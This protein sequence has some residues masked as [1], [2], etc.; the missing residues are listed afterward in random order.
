M[1]A[2]SEYID[3]HKKILKYILKRDEQPLEEKYEKMFNGL[4]ETLVRRKRTLLSIFLFHLA[5]MTQR[6][7]NIIIATFLLYSSV[8]VQK[9]YRFHDFMTTQRNQSESESIQ[10]DAVIMSCL[11]LFLEV[12]GH[13]FISLPSAFGYFI[14]T[15]QNQY[16]MIVFILSMCA[17]FGRHEIGMRFGQM[18]FAKH[19]VPEMRLEGA[20][21]SILTPMLVSYFMAKSDYFLKLNP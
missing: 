5:I 12:F 13:L 9:M 3:I 8:F 10:R 21:L 18:H 11:S 2:M 4:M 16:L 14:Y 7:S 19:V 15:N 20:I 1:K 17:D 6:H